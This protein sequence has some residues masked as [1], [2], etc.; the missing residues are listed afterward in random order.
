VNKTTAGL[1]SSPMNLSSFLK[2]EVVNPWGISRDNVQVIEEET[3]VFEYDG[4]EKYNSANILG[5]LTF[6][7]VCGVILHTLG[8]EGKPLVSWFKCLYDV[9]LKLVDLFMW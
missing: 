2:T 3:V 9:T 6:S 1:K 8:E 7:V 4:Q 5:I